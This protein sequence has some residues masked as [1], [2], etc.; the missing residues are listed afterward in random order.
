MAPHEAMPA[1]SVSVGSAV[2]L[3]GARRGRIG[4]PS[5]AKG[6]HL[7]H[8]LSCRLG[9][10][11][12]A[13]TPPRWRHGLDRQSQ[14]RLARRARAAACEYPWPC[15]PL[16]PGTPVRGGHSRVQRG[17]RPLG[18]QGLG[19]PNLLWLLLARLVF[20]LL[21]V[22]LAM[23][24]ISQAMKPTCACPPCSHCPC[25]RTFPSR[26]HFTEHVT[27]ARGRRVGHLQACTSSPELL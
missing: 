17:S 8:A 26:G 19:W 4:A 1:R 12:R 14:A 10:P 22:G 15:S 13:N 7:G 23:P 16:V 24:R 21:I 5:P 9:A 20:S 2:V 11:R 25:C 27:C 18:E 3:Q 6:E